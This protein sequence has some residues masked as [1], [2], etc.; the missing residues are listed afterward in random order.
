MAAG[1]ASIY[2]GILSTAER[3]GA[4]TAQHDDLGRHMLS[5][6]EMGRS[7]PRVRA[8]ETFF[9]SATRDP[10]LADF[11]ARARYS[12]GATTMSYLGAAAPW[13]TRLDAL[14]ISHWISGA[15]RRV[16]VDADRALDIQ[17]SIPAFAA[18]LFPR[19]QD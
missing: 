3:W 10:A 5:F 18:T 6:L 13:L 17:Q 9:F 11:A 7:A 16:I 2:E 4:I 19:P 8:F 15:A 1:Y 14:L 12:R